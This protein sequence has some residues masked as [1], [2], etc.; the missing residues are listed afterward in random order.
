ME[1]IKFSSKIKSFKIGGNAALG[2]PSEKL[3][4]APHE[5]FEC[6]PVLSGKRYKIKPPTASHA[7]YVLIF[8]AE[9]NG[10]IRPW[11]IFI[12]T[13]NPEHRMM[14]DTVTRLVSALF[15]KGGEIGFIAEELKDIYD[16][17]GG[18]R[19]KGGK[20]YNSIIHEIGEVVENH[21]NNLFYEEEFT[22][23]E[24]KLPKEF[25]N[26]HEKTDITLSSQECPKCRS[27]NTALM[28]GCLQCLDCGD[29]KCG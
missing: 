28:D 4:E 12:Q 19:Q 27:L 9:I 29:S 7:V 10:V 21:I 6:P 17:N 15:R 13:K 20:W 14:T 16:A 5:E 23:T 2:K 26:K 11:E 3:S 24:S 18:Y 8:D 1:A 25:Q 22:K